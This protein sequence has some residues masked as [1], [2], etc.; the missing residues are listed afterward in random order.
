MLCNKYV[1]TALLT[2]WV[3][4]SFCSMA[5]AEDVILDIGNGS[6]EP[7]SQNSPVPLSLDN[8]SDTVAGVHLYICDEGNY[9][10]VTS[11]MS[12][13][14]ASGFFCTFNECKTD[15]KNAECRRYPGC[16]NI[17][18]YSTGETIA[19]GKGPIALI[20]YAVSENAPSGCIAL[21]PRSAKAGRPK[22]QGVL[23][24]RELSVM[25]ER[26]EFCV[27]GGSSDDEDT[28]DRDANTSNPE[29]SRAESPTEQTDSNNSTASAGGSAAPAASAQS[30]F[31]TPMGGSSGTIQETSSDSDADTFG[32]PE[33]SSR[34]RTT[35]GRGSSASRE[36]DPRSTG[37]SGSNSAS[38]SGE[39][40]LIISPS[41]SVIN[42][43]GMLALDAQTIAD[44]Q[45]VRGKY[46]WA[47]LPPSTIGSTIDENGVF[48]A[49]VNTSST[50]VQETIRVTDASH[51][52][53]SGTATITIEGLQES[54]EGCSLLVTPSSAEIAPGNVITFTAAKLGKT[55]GEGS[56]HW[57]VNSKIGSTITGEGVYTAGINRGNA[58]VLDIILLKDSIEDLSIDALVK[59][60][61]GDTF[62]P[63]AG[64][65]PI[66]A[67][68]GSD[69]TGS[70]LLPGTLIAAAAFF[71]VVGVLLMRKKK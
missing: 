68:S 2:L 71:A 49:G 59:V 29:N 13:G 10:S 24:Q 37:T 8:A 5:Y 25:P 11:C 9:L 30:G 51:K 65:P 57:K 19:A 41:L 53:I 56:Y 15:A 42:S 40:R 48:T 43:K 58:A 66:T 12:T 21:S 22:I 64:S 32:S 1:T 69:K 44:G 61:P 54:A 38:G 27:S 18:I 20:N 39:S 36:A 62:A 4:I 34:N 52:S 6:G 67:D 47:I 45:E 46:K 23:N 70:P 17:M 26:G 16:A 14:R 35:G 60:A 50:P 55:C 28:S 31:R 3:T 33:T 7:G 63:A